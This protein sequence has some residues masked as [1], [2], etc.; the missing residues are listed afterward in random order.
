[1]AQITLNSTGVASSGSLVLQSNGTTTAVTVD[2]SQNV[3]IGVTPSAWSGFTALQIT[4]GMSLWSSASGN[5][6]Y[7]NNTYYDGTNRKYVYTGTACEYVQSG[8]S[9]IWKTAASGAAGNTVTFTQAMTLDPS[10][11]LGIGT[12]SPGS[13]YASQLVVGSESSGYGSITLATTSTGTNSIYF[14]R[15]NSGAGRYRG[16]IGYDQTSDAITFRNAGD[17]E[18]ARITSD[19]RFFLGKTAA[20]AAN[21]GLEV[22][23]TGAVYSS[24]AAST[25]SSYTYHVYSTTASAFRFYVGMGGTVYATSIVITAISDQRLKENVRDIETG[26]D[27]IMALKPRRFDWKDGKGQDKKDAAGFI[28][29]EFAEVFPASVSAGK[30]GGDGIEYLTMNHEELIPSLVKSIQEQQAIIESLKA[31][32]DAANL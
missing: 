10:G 26:L 5:A 27:A 2:A 17:T 11:Y 4:N 23:N 18:R 20:G 6:Y 16:S 9:H 1:M 29:Q 28:A 31:R 24:L 14:A 32:L 19:G 21:V 7:N 30:A 15:S 8:G 12:T 13:F 22:L 3:G 25:D